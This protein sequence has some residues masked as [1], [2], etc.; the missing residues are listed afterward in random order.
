MPASAAALSFIL[1]YVDESDRAPCWMIVS[2]G[3]KR[4]NWAR[5]EAMRD[6]MSPRRELQRSW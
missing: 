1:T 2:R 4:G 5:T 3:V 6:A